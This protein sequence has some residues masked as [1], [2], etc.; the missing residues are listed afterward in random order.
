MVMQLH[1]N[2]LPKLNS[3]SFLEGRFVLNEINKKQFEK[4]TQKFRQEKSSLIDE[5]DKAY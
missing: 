4:L 1:Y 5:K 2:R 3:E